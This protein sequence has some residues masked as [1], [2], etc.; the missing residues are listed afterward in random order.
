M[1]SATGLEL[2]LERCTSLEAFA[3]LRD[4]WNALLE[5]SEQ[6]TLFMR[7][8]WLHAWFQYFADGRELMLLLARDGSGKL[9][10]IGPFCVKKEQGLPPARSLAFIGTTRIS[11]E[12]LDLIVD[13]AQQAAVRELLIGA[14]VDPSAP[15][16]R[17]RV[18]DMLE[19]SQLLQAAGGLDDGEILVEVDEDKIC[20][21]MDLPDDLE[22]FMQQMSSKN[23]KM[24]RQ[25]T[26]KLEAAGAAFERIETEQELQGALVDLFRLHKERWTSRGESGNFGDDPVQGFH[27][28]VAADLLA[29]GRL[30]LY[31][32]KAE[33]KRLAMLYGF[34]DGRT[35]SYFQAGM[36]PEW[37]NL[38]PGFVL[39]GHVV[40]DA[41]EHGLRD[42]DFLR[43]PERYKQR[44]TK[45]ERVTRRATLTPRASWK[46]MARHKAE[47]SLRAAK[48]AAK[49]LLRREEE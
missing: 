41:I 29:S 3:G 6:R 12:Y 22:S 32:L 30:G 36:D 27:Q 45:E 39:I 16:D 8:E 19:S 44:W 4:E 14:M 47:K 2:R 48:S 23:R 20:P 1:T 38:S 49:K 11:S 31:A 15:W 28:Q 40:G 7:H 24:L 18:G 17:V 33:G 25:Y 13:P 34:R 43:G 42:F 26:R 5:R 46:G 9:C 10:G 35:F 37:A 21:R